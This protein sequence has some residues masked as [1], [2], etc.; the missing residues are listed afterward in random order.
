MNQK[1]QTSAADSLRPYAGIEPWVASKGA[2]E[3]LGVKA[4]WLYNNQERLGIPRAKFGNTYRYK[5]SQ[6]DTWAE[7]QT[8]SAR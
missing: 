5:L 7:Q 8:A 4:S 3:H 6:L 2:A 1:H